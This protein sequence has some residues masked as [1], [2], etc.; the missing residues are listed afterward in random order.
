MHGKPKKPTWTLLN[1]TAPKDTTKLTLKEPVNWEAGDKIVV[2]SSSHSFDEAE[3]LTIVGIEDG[4][5][6]IEVDPP[7][8]YQHFGEV[9][10]YGGQ[11]IDMR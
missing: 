11:E 6:V 4:G 9:L 5:L 3:E 8:E 7:L 2:A 10:S 1:K